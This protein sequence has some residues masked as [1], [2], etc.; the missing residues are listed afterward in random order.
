M[1]CRLDYNIKFDLLSTLEQ[2]FIPHAH[3]TQSTHKITIFRHKINNNKDF[4]LDWIGRES[5]EEERKKDAN[6]HNSN[7]K[8]RQ[9]QLNR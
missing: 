4:W 8:K 5:K 6:D 3:N 1:I 7:K 2:F 9:Q